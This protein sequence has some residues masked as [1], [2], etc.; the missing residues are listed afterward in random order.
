VVLRDQEI[1]AMLTGEGR[2]A[3]PWILL[4]GLLFWFSYRMQQRML[5]VAA[6]A[7]SAGPLGHE[8]PPRAGVI[9]PGAFLVRDIARERAY[10]VATTTIVDEEIGKL[11]RDIHSNAREIL[12][13]H[14]ELLDKLAKT[15]EERETLDL[16]DS[17]ALLGS[18]NKADR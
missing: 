14:R 9:S 7:C 2:E 10:S 8:P 18:A 16:E 3:L 15:L 12:E 4:L 13:Q 11:L 5:G 6:V 17:K 1:T